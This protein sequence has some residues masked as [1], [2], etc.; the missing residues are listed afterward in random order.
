MRNLKLE[1]I[2]IIVYQL[3]FIKCYHLKYTQKSIIYSQRKYYLIKFIANGFNDFNG[4]V[5]QFRNTIF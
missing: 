5:S 4:T 2:H 1:I 3:H